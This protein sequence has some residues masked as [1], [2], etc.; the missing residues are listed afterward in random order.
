MNLFKRIIGTGMAFWLLVQ[1]YSVQGGSS[2]KGEAAVIVSVDPSEIMVD[3]NQSASLAIRIES[4]VA[5][6]GAYDIDLVWTPSVFQVTG[7]ARGSSPE[8]GTPISNIRNDQ[9]RLTIAGFQFSSLTG[10]TGSFTIATVNFT[11]EGSGTTEVQLEVRE[12]SDTDGMPLNASVMGGSVSISAS[13]T[14]TPTPTVE[15]TPTPTSTPDGVPTALRPELDGDL[16]GRIGHGDLI[17]ILKDGTIPLD[18]F[19]LTIDWG[20]PTGAE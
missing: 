11:S 13:G 8:F 7:V 20:R 1:P 17:L 4:D 19:Y 9:G 5:P 3:S 10:P 16:D 2:N 12:L 14:S 6:I 15:T 18:L